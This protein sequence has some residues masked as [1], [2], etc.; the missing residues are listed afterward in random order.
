MEVAIGGKALRKKF[1]ADDLSV[2]Q[3][4]A[5]C[6]LVGKI[7]PAIPVITSGYPMPKSNV[8]NRVKRIE[9]RQTEWVTVA[10]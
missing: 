7:A 5:A 2:L 8:V 4:Q 1:G 6:S 10:A 9:V 3:D